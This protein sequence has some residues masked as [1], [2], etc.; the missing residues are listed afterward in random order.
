MSSIIDRNPK[1]CLLSQYL[2][3]GKPL[4]CLC[5]KGLVASAA[6]LKHL[7]SLILIEEDEK[8]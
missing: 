2:A 8:Q 7:W 6:P 5:P 1:P 4:N 3:A